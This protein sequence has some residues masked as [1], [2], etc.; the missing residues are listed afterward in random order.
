MYPKDKLRLCHKQLPRD[1]DRWLRGVT[2]QALLARACS[3]MLRE[4]GIHLIIFSFSECVL[5]DD[6]SEDMTVALH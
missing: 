4:T 6:P 5:I 1:V 2:Y 3:N